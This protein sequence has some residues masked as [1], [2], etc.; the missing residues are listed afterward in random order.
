[1]AHTHLCLLYHVIFATKDREPWLTVELRQPIFGYMAG[2]LKNLNGQAILIN[3]AADH[4][5]V[6][7]RLRA[8]SAVADVVQR[9]KS[10]SSGW[11]HKTF[12]RAAFAWQEGYAAFSVSASQK[13]RVHQY[14]AQQDKH[15]R[16]RSFKEEYLE[17]LKRHGVEYDDRF[18]WD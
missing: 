7:C 13:N 3:G 16:L 17:L 12:R 11:V 1:M 4:A 14:I 5:H 15:H 10:N 18:V 2:I 8:T 6:L 9:V